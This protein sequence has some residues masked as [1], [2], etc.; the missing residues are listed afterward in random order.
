MKVKKAFL[1]TINGLKQ[2]IFIILAILL[3]ISIIQNINIKSFFNLLGN[4]FI[5]V[6]IWDIFWS[7]FAGNPINSYILIW[8]LWNFE[9][10]MIVFSVFLISWVTVW[11]IQ[12]PAEIHF[13]GKKFT[14]L[15]NII[16]FIL[17]IL[18]AY[19][20]YFIMLYIW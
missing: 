2:N 19:I 8:G 13:F 9:K 1:S 6:F 4:N 17:A 12:L 15:R 3:I 16:S 5:S 11:F 10:N 14:F 20:V 18:C 7:I